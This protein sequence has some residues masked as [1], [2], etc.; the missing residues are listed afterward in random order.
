MFGSMKNG[1]NAYAKVGVETGVMAANP[2][3]L[4]VMLFEGAETAVRLARQQMANGDVPAKGR[5]ISKA[6]NIIDNGLR[7]SLDKK[8]GGEIAANLESLYEYM[9]GR[10]V[11]ANL[12]NS[13]EMLQE[14]L[15][16]LGELRGA[17]EAIAP[18]T[19]AMAPAAAAP[20]T[21]E[22]VAPVA[23]VAAFA[24]V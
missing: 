24:R 5:S 6:I 22:H 21:G 13:P 15:Q 23:G 12:H 20:H 4:I 11:L 16:L 7:A 2:H 14:V 10:L 17:W 19:P 8:A 9:V 3:K 18:G 1:A